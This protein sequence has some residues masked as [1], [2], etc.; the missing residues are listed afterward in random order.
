MEELYY[1]PEH[2]SGY[3]GVER[4]ALAARQRRRPTE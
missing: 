4:L 2:P 1:N 3:G